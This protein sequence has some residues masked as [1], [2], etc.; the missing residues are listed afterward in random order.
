MRTGSGNAGLDPIA[1]SGSTT[2]FALDVS[3]DII[4]TAPKN[5]REDITIR[6]GRLL[7]KA[8]VLKFETGTFS[9]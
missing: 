5:G 6:G 2:K 3:P 1:E 7:E 9:H 8:C 4:V